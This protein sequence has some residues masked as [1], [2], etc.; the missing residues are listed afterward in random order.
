MP[1]AY[2]FSERLAVS[3]GVSANN[4]VSDILVNNIPGAV[5]AMLAHPVNDRNGT[6]WWVEHAS[7]KHLSVD[8][9]IREKDWTTRMPPEDD[10][11]LETWSVV[12]RQVI[13]WTRNGEKRTDYILWLW[14][15]TGRWCLMPFPML[16]RVFSENWRAW[17]MRYKTSRQFTPDR[18]YHSECVFV[19]R[20]EVWAQIYRTF[21]GK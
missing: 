16:C 18:G 6:D 9:K 4:N 5:N 21:G 1:R 10:L 17:I 20:R 14:L 7:G 3:R 12:E 19:P 13:G 8:C 15:D 11:A 2:S